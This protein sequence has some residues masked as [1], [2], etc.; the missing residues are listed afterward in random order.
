[1]QWQNG[2]S[3]H[4]SDAFGRSRHISDCHRRHATAERLAVGPMTIANEQPRR[5]VPRESFGDLLG[6]PIGCRVRAYTDGYQLPSIVAQ[7]DEHKEDL[8][9]QRWD[10]EEIDRGRA[11]EVVTEQGVDTLT[12]AGRHDASHEEMWIRLRRRSASS[13][14]LQPGMCGVWIGR[15]GDAGC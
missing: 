7:D 5:L 15:S 12:R 9:S 1:M 3:A 8:E 6:G 14:L 13:T 10:N 2:L 4:A 11:M